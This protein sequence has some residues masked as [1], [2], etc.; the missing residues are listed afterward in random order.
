MVAGTL[1]R[2]MLSEHNPGPGSALLTSVVN[3]AR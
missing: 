3:N 1:A 2:I